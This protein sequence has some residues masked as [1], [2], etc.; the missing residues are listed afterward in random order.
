MFY[1]LRQDQK[2]AWFRVTDD[3][4]NDV[5]KWYQRKEISKANIL[6]FPLMQTLEISLMNPYNYE[7]SVGK[8]YYIS[9]K[10]NSIAFAF[11]PDQYIAKWF[12]P[13][14][15]TISSETLAEI[16]SQSTQLAKSKFEQSTKS[17]IQDSIIADN[18]LLELNDLND[19]NDYYSSTSYKKQIEYASEHIDNWEEEPD[20]PDIADQAE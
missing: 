13:M 9:I 11:K 4:I 7:L 10:Q 3:A 16:Y 5:L 17:T 8:Q 2:H 6:S 14:K 15:Q 18:Y 1:F 19:Q 20:E 12:R